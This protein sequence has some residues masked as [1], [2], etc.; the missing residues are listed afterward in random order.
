M[1]KFMHSVQVETDSDGNIRIVQDEHG[2]PDGGHIV[3]LTP[4]QVPTLIEWL[5]EAA[6]EIKNPSV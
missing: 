1:K 4:E 5:N 2:S 6:K 3:I